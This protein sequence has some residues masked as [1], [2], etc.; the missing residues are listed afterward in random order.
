M[1]TE[2]EMKKAE[3]HRARIKLYGEEVKET[4]VENYIHKEPDDPAAMILFTPKLAAYQYHIES[5]EIID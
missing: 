5:I 1:V 4:F 3:G 2:Q